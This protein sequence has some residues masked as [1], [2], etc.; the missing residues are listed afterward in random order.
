MQWG[1]ERAL[2]VL[3]EIELTMIVRHASQ[4][5]DIPGRRWPRKRCWQ[6]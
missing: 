3:P 1:W 6:T 4:A 2:A 5:A